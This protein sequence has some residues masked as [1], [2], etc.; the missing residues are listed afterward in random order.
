MSYLNNIHYHGCY[1]CKKPCPT[2]Q[3]HC[4]ECSGNNS[5]IS[6]GYYPTHEENC[7]CNQC[8]K[9]ISPCS[10]PNPPCCNQVEAVGSVEDTKCNPQPCDNGCIETVNSKCV[11]LDTYC[12]LNDCNCAN[13]PI[14]LDMFLIQLC[15]EITKIK[16][17]ID[18][19]KMHI[20]A[21]SGNIT[22]GVPVFTNSIF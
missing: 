13:E 20:P 17:D 9:K 22:C 4:N 10:T 8:Q 3:T 19:L 11:I 16:S 21:C 6:S 15:A 1:S 5:H 14:N 12:L 7:G 2:T 18:C